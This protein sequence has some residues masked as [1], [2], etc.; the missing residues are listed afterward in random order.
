MD[1]RRRLERQDDYQVSE[2]EPS[3]KS[4][5]EE[6]SLEKCPTPPH[7][8]KLFSALFEIDKSPWCGL[9]GSIHAETA[10]SE[11]SSDEDRFDLEAEQDLSDP[12]EA[13]IPSFPRG[14]VPSLLDLS[15][16]TSGTVH[17][18]EFTR[19]DALIMRDMYTP[20]LTNFGEQWNEWIE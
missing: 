8:R 1:C 4:L 12:I 2:V 11:L 14:G 9:L 16:K 3:V 6:D 18:R 15:S 20:A 5:I 17:Q 19:K 7:A 13:L 10:I